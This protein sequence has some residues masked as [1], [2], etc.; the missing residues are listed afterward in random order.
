MSR[1]LRLILVM[2]ISLTLP[3]TGMAGVPSSTEPCP[4]KMSDMQMMAD[5]S[6]DCCQDG[7]ASADHG[8]ACKPGQECKTGGLLQLSMPVLKAPLTPAHPL[9]V[10]LSSDFIPDRSPS[11]VWRPPRS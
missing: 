1:L 5:M 4:M 10:S 8:K 9:A 11:G 6:P 2:L 3:L 7:A